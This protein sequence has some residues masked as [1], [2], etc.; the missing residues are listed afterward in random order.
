MIKS[1]DLSSILL[2]GQCKVFVL[3][4]HFGQRV[5]WNWCAACVSPKMDSIQQNVEFRKIFTLCVYTLHTHTCTCIIRTMYGAESSDYLFR[6]EVFQSHEQIGLK[7]QNV[8]YVA[9]K[10][11]QGH[12]LYMA[13]RPYWNR[14]FHVYAN[15]SSFVLT[16]H[17]KRCQRT[18]KYTKDVRQGRGVEGKW[19]FSYGRVCAAIVSHL[20]TPTDEHNI[21][22]ERFS[23]AALC[24]L[25]ISEKLGEYGFFHAES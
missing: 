16:C 25:N 14:L 17:R 12:N 21:W 22:I 1:L 11:K 2:F 4:V 19:Q 8:T 20:I 10:K 7:F 5:A 13:G 3:L 24:L 9:N 23:D 15:M 18:I 6:R